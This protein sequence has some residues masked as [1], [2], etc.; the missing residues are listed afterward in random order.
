MNTDSHNDQVSIAN[1]FI[2][3][4]FV[5]LFLRLIPNSFFPK[6]LPL[7][8]SP[9][10]LG[11]AE[12]QD[13]KIYLGLLIVIFLISLAVIFKKLKL[14]NWALHPLT[15][16]LLLGTLFASTV[17]LN[18]FADL[19]E[20]L[21]FGFGPDIAL[22]NLML[23]FSIYFRASRNDS[24]FEI[25]I[26]TEFGMVFT[27]ILLVFYLPSVLQFSHGIID[28]YH[29][30]FIFNE[31]AAPSAGRAPLSSF[32]AQY[33]NLLG[34][35]L[36]LISKIHKE[37]V[38]TALPY[39]TTLLT[40][41]EFLIIGLICRKLFKKLHVS[42]AIFFPLCLI[43]MKQNQAENIGGSIAALLSALPIRTLFPVLLLFWLLLLLENRNSKVIPVVLGLLCGLTVLNN[44]EFGITSFISIF[45][46]VF[47]L[48]MFRHLRIVHLV[49]I[50]AGAAASLLIFLAALS[51]Q[52]EG[53]QLRRLTAFSVGFGNV[54]FGNVPM[55]LFG[56]FVIIFTT[57]GLGVVLGVL[58]IRS[59]L[60][61]EH[62]NKIAN[63][64]ITSSSVLLYAG[65]WG[66]LSLP[67]YIARSVN[68]GQLQVFLIPVALVVLGMAS[69]FF[70][71]DSVSGQSTRL[72]FSARLTNLPLLFIICLPISSVLNHPDPSFEWKRVMG[73]GNELSVASIKSTPLVQSLIAYQLLNHAESI[74][75]LGNWGNLINL[76]TGITSAIDQNTLNDSSMTPYL[77]QTLCDSILNSGS[78]TL[79]VEH[80]TMPVKNLSQMCE[81]VS[82]VKAWDTNIDVYKKL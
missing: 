20:Q 44:F 14:I 30:S 43:L 7:I 41:A 65:T 64:S 25:N 39:W 4:S 16:M 29:S 22:V 54:G 45:C 17:A 74:S 79:L 3:C 60:F 37:W 63:N 6:N 19:K 18:Y 32:T 1:F 69:N 12:F 40:L 75:F 71:F 49:S 82:F 77:T 2:L 5:P 72:I 62:I 67:Y 53:I 35:P 51:T 8:S 11:A 80:A 47:A 31:L 13:R 58:G 34:Y 26:R 55:P 21:W 59:E 24:N 36:V 50:T 33:S 56:T 66:T 27:L 48:V 52:T 68:S 81:R 78:G 23:V 46:T 70:V 28:I 57:L 76:E 61:P 38:I 15:T 9:S 42:I 73:A 10:L